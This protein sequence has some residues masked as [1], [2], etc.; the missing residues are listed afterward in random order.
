M[1]HKEVS[2]AF[3]LASLHDS[4]GITVEVYLQDVQIVLED[5]KVM[6]LANARANTVCVG[7]KLNKYDL[8]GT[9]CQDWS[10][11]SHFKMN[12]PIRTTSWT[13]SA[14]FL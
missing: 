12:S 7:N 2:V 6:W 5:P 11:K 9:F 10:I 3:V 13:H 1:H 4:M 14:P 8:Q